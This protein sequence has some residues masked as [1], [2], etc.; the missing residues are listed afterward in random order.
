MKEILVLAEHRRGELRDITFEMLS[1]AN[2]LAGEN[3]MT[4][5]AL[6][7]GHEASDLSDG[8]K[9]ACDSIVIMDDPKLANCNADPYLVAM[10]LVLK[11]RKP[12]LTLIGH[13]AAGMD[14]APALATRLSLPLATDC[15]E[16]NLV[17]GRLEVIRQIYGGKINAYL[18]MKP[19]EQY[20]ISIR[21]GSAAAEAEQGK[22]GATETVP[23]PS[24]E[25]LKGRRFLDYLEAELEDIDIAVADILVSI[26]RGIGK[27]ENIPVAQ[28]FAD[29]IGATLACSRPVADKEWLPKSRQV[30]T[31]G[32]TVNP[33]IYIALGIS[34][35]FQHQAGMKNANTI[36]AVN[37]D[38]RAPIFNVAHYGIVDDL[39][40]VLPLLKE[41][42]T[43]K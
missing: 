2:R 20:L 37:K 40:K 29:A 42:F 19:F 24:W 15:L 23:V 7:L 35:A 17:E 41:K 5:T 39:F 11:E 1:M 27:P 38:P 43:K 12:L 16:V 28:E 18:T 3:D 30:G 34:G 26:G 31:S 33:K 21:P 36:I 25:N 32:K 4:V 9:G 13:T 22:S 14:L 8:L 10:E 6:F